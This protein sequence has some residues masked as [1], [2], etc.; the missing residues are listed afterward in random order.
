MASPTRHFK[1]PFLSKE[2]CRAAA[3]QFRERYCPQN[4]IP[5]DVLALVEFELN[6]EIRTITGLKEDA[7]VDALL[8]GDWKTLILDQQQ[9]LDDRFTNRLRFSIAHELGHFALHKEVFQS[10]PRKNADEWISFMLEMP[11]KEY[12]LL[13]FHANEFAG[14]LLVPIENLKTQFASV[15]DELESTGFKLQQLSDEHISYLCV[16]LAKHFAVSQE[17]IERRLSKEKL[18]PL[19]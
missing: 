3:D 13:E 12:G 4:E 18:W 7:D 15:L 6:L 2:I 16:P 8:L 17:V 9:F 14:R 5:I 1:A 19:S 10:I 11:E